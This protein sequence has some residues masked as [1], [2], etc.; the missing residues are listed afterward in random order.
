MGRTAAIVALL[1]VACSSPPPA[2]TA[3]ARFDVGPAPLAFDAAPFP[4]DF[5]LAAD[6]TIPIGALPSTRS[7]SPVVEHLRTLLAA[8]RGFCATCSIYFPID[9]TL[10]RASVPT[11][12]T[13]ADGDAVMLVDVDPTSATLGRR[14]PLRVEWNEPLHLV[15]FRPARGIALLAH[16]TYAAAI[17]SKLR[18][19]DG[20][21][22]APSPSF[23]PHRE[24][25]TRG[26]PM[27]AGSDVRIVAATVFTTEDV[28]SELRD[29]RAVVHAAPAP[30]VSVDR[31]YHAGAELD[32]LLGVPSETRPGID[33]VPMTGTT[34][35]RSIRHAALSLVVSGR[36]RAPRLVTGTGTEVGELLRDASGHIGVGALEDVTFVLLVPSGAD[37]THLPV[38][39]HQHGFNASRTTGFVLGDTAAHAGFAVLSVDAYQHG[40]RAASAV[41]NAHALRG[42][43]VPG[44]DGFAETTLLDVSGRVFGLTGVPSDDALY[45]GYPLGAF[46]QFAADVMAA[47]RLVLEGDLA[48]LRA[49]DPSL[50]A[51]AFDGTRIAYAGNSMGSVVGTSVLTVEPAIHRAILNVPPGSI[52]ETLVESPE[53]RPLTTGVFLPTLGVSPRGFDEVTRHLEMDPMVDMIRWALEPIDPLALAPTLLA[54]RVDGGTAPDILFQR[55]MLD[56]VAWTV[57]TESYLTAAGATHV[58]RYDP[59]GHG[60]LEVQDQ[61]SAWQPPYEPPLMPRTP[62]LPVTN[63]LAAIHL[64]IE[65]FLASP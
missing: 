60:M 37:L 13:G 32:D 18:A 43:G 9:G 5:R 26:L 25:L 20:T 38:L 19:T 53:F 12:V 1:A 47:V 33:V 64:E 21:P 42:D 49:A 35:T 51:L 29:A 14:F 40:E 10:D 52:T 24:S 57:A 8:R 41:D 50:A 62:V 36:F 15:T 17:T 11:S 48:P 63:P 4:G 7:D 2:P 22:L 45:P 6:G 34:G 65:T 55:A 46:V 23:E 61:M 58:T 28:T 3:F 54:N 56:E 16:H 30:T 59:A 39:V 31:V 27:D 44:A